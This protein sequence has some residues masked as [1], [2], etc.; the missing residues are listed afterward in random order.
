M[1]LDEWQAEIAKWSLLNFGDQ[2]SDH[3]LL[4]VAEE[5]GELCHHHL[6]G[7]QGIR[8]NEE[9]KLCKMDAVGDIII[10]LADYCSREGFS[11]RECLKKATAVVLSRDWKANKVDGVGD[12]KK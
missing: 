10:Y 9:H 7:K 1:T 8:I 3:P 5:L 12:D 11:L 4:G 6:K 2:P